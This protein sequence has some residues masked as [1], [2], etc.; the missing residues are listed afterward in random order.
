MNRANQH[1]LRASFHW[2][3]AALVLAMLI[4][5]F[6][7]L[8]SMPNA[9]PR[10]I[11]VLGLHMTGGLFILLL[12]AA[13][14]TVR[15]PDPEGVRRGKAARIA[16][17]G[18][19]TLIVLLLVTGIVTALL[20]RLPS[21]ILHGTAAD[22]PARFTNFPTF[23]AHTLLAE[24]LAVLA[25]V[26]VISAVFHQFVLKDGLLSRM[27]FGATRGPAGTAKD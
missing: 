5:G 3:L 11:A 7:W 12:L 24:L 8:R 17:N 2:A 9:D 14:L 19:Y 16:H 4:I 6:F 15:I 25:I 21:I 1:S 22:L 20:A 13:R 27:M 18:I 26:H 23:I 10:K